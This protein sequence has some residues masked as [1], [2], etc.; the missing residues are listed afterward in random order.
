MQIYP[1]DP[2][3]TGELKMDPT[4]AHLLLDRALAAASRIALGD[5]LSRDV[6]AESLEA[7]AYAIRTQDVA[8]DMSPISIPMA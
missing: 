8:E 3:N 6:V 2:N 7:E 1:H 4:I 5:G